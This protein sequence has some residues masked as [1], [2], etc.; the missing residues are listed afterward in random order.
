MK[1]FISILLAL[2]MCLTACASLSACGDADDVTTTAK[3][4]KSSLGLEFTL[5]S[6]GKS[7]AVS[8]IGECKDTKIIIP[9]TY[10]SLPVMS[11]EEEAFL[12]CAS[13]ESVKI[14]DS[15]TDIGYGAFKGTSAVE[16]AE[17]VYYVDNWAVDCEDSAESVTIREGTVGIA[18]SISANCEALKT[19][20]IADSVKYICEA[21]FGFRDT[22]RTVNLPKNLVSIGDSAFMQCRNLYIDLVIPEGTQYIGE[23]AFYSCIKLKSITIPKSVSYVGQVAFYNTG[24]EEE[25]DG[26][27][28]VDTWVVRTDRISTATIREGTYGIAEK[29]FNA[30]TDSLVSLAQL[31]KVVIPDSLIYISPDAFSKNGKITTFSVGNG[32]TAFKVVNGNLYSKDGSTLIKCATGKSNP[33]TVIEEGTVT[34]NDFAFFHLGTST[35]SEITIPESVRSIGYNAFVEWQAL[36]SVTFEST[37]GWVIRNTETGEITPFIVTDPSQNAETLKSGYYSNDYSDIYVIEKR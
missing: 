18:R 2:I 24:C 23:A 33:V 3:Q 15:I 16:K 6:D 26:V 37:E 29:G 32:N 7:Y 17:N 28:Y 22:L 36:S 12:N 19:V 9:S 13:I 1:R 11:I 8:G 20:T 31:K 5:N 27:Y 10:N 34:V 30:Y 4:E 35:V 21:S 14:P 25:L